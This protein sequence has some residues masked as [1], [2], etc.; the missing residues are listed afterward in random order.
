ML[1]LELTRAHDWK[2][3]WADTTDAFKTRR[4]RRLQEQM[5]ALLPAGWVV[6]VV[7]LT[8]GIR[9]SLH[10]PTWSRILVRRDRV[11]EDSFLGS[12][13]SFDRVFSA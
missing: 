5:E 8:I 7:P 4:Y 2:Q 13:V 9:G 6:Q 1:L 12:C 11:L 10:V 3:D